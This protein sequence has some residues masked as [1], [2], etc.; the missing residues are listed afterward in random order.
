MCTLCDFVAVTVGEMADMAFK[1]TKELSADI[2]GY[3]F[4][5]RGL[6][7]RM[8]RVL[9]YAQQAWSP[10]FDLKKDISLLETQE[11]VQ[12]RA[13]KLLDCIASLSYEDRLK[14]LNLYGIEDR[15]KHGDMILMYRIMND[16]AHLDVRRNFYSQRVIIPWN[17]LPQHVAESWSID[18]FKF[19]YDKWSG[20][21]LN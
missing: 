9:K 17:E 5:P 15:S 20:K 4:T 21:I 12:Q 11:S 8:L 14:S 13:T 19:N 6:Y 18:S 2:G 7:L 16:D 10:H 1:Q 3:I